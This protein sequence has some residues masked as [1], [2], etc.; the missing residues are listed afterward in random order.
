[1]RSFFIFI[2]GAILGFIIAEVVGVFGYLLY[3]QTIG[4]KFFPFLLGAVLGGIDIILR[5]KSNTPMYKS[6]LRH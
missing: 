4:V 5:K 3:D 1:M 2:T 6:S